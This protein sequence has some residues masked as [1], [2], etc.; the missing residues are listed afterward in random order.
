VGG[1]DPT[2]CWVGGKGVDDGK[3]RTCLREGEKRGTYHRSLKPLGV[4]K[5][6]EIKGD[7]RK[8]MGK[9]RLSNLAKLIRGRA[10][11][12]ANFQRGGR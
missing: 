5:E 10:Y 4:S 2:V 12:H 3:E 11:E 9:R 7:D 8:T 6:N 1:F